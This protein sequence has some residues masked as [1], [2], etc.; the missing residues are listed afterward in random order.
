MIIPEDTA[1]VSTSSRPVTV[2]SMIVGNAARPALVCIVHSRLPFRGPSHGSS[3][4]EASKTLAYGH[5]RTREQHAL[6]RL[7]PANFL[8]L[9][10]A[11]LPRAIFRDVQ[12]GWSTQSTYRGV[13]DRTDD[14]PRAA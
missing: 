13:L 4:E 7:I 8:V 10:Y 14:T 11:R 12:Q 5:R 6:S 3:G 9:M 1:F 2:L